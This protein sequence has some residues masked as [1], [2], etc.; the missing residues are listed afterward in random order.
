MFVKTKATDV[1]VR[2]SKQVRQEN[3]MNVRGSGPTPTRKVD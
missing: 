3:V 2:D 1:R